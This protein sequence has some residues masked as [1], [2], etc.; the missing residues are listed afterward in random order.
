MA[1]KQ[2]G[3]VIIE[4]KQRKQAVYKVTVGKEHRGV[5]FFQLQGAVG[6]LY[7]EVEH[8]LVHLAVAVSSYAKG[9]GLNGVKHF[10]NCLSVVFSRQIV[11]GTVVE[12]VAQKNNSIRLF[13]RYAL[14]K[15]LAAARRAV[16]IRCYQKFHLLVPPWCFCGNILTQ[17][18]GF[19][20]RNP[21]FKNFDDI[22]TKLTIKNK[23]ILK[24]I[25]LGGIIQ[26][27]KYICEYE[28]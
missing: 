23:N 24:I 28:Q 1:K 14:C 26:K 10:G 20:K 22:V 11:A 21:K 15:R 12:Q 5:L 9:R 6:A 17:Y 13:F 25:C 19:G 2:Y 27:Y 16:Y 7:G 3:F 18:P 4:F 8:H